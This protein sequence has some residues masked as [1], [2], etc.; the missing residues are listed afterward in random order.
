MK[1]T[2]VLFFVLMVFA[3]LSCNKNDESPEVCDS[4]C[5][6]DVDCHDYMLKYCPGFLQTFDYKICISNVFYKCQT[7]PGSSCCNGLD[8]VFINS[9]ECEV[10]TKECVIDAP[11]PD[12]DWRNIDGDLETE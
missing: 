4:Q 5:S 8:M 11:P 2:F 3:I 9:G 6:T 7:K 10:Q 1:K 12:S